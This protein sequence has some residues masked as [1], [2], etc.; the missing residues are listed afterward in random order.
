M[1]TPR[2]PI[3]HKQAIVQQDNEIISNGTTTG[4]IYKEL[5][6]SQSIEFQFEKRPDIVL[7]TYPSNEELNM[8]SNAGIELIIKHVCYDSFVFIT[9]R[10]NPVESLT[11]E[12]I[13]KIYSGNI[14]N[15]KEVGGDN[16]SIVA[17]QCEQNFS[18]WLH[19]YYF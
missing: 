13:Q 4:W 14:A 17:Y 11:V 9:H 1:T 16:Q 3:V 12:Q 18:R 5:S 10:D 2:D 15:W 6:N 7:A 19:R 8:A